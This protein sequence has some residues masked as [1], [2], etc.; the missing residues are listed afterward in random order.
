MRLPPLRPHR[1]KSAS[2]ICPSTS[3]STSASWTAAT[4]AEATRMATRM[5]KVASPNPTTTTYRRRTSDEEEWPEGESES[6]DEDEESEDDDDDD[7]SDGGAT[8]NGDANALAGVKKSNRLLREEI[9][10]HQKEL[11]ALKDTDP[12]FYKFLQ[13]EDSEL[14]DFDESEGEESEDDEDEDG[15][16]DKKGKGSFSDAKTLTSA[17]VAKLCERAAGGE[18]LGA[19]RN[20]FRAYRAAAHYGDEDG[21]EEAGVKLASSAAFHSLV[22]F[23]LEE[24]D[25]ILR[26]LL[27]QPPRGTPTRRDYSSLISSRGGK[28]S[29]PLRSRSWATPCTC[30]V[31]SRTRTCQGF[32]SPGSTCVFRS[33]IHSS[34]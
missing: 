26:G 29:S 3:S 13:T 23:V 21:D 18:A 4:T 17:T 10:E 22:T 1:G 25:T 5:A 16:G 27:G 19:A 8:E 12:E 31:S 7:D 2:R 6:D 34:A 24:A 33:C 14:L 30:W 15:E 9:E 20:L 32:C 28:R 11:E